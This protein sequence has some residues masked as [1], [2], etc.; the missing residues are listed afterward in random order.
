MKATLQIDIVRVDS[1]D[2]H[3]ITRSHVL[4]PHGGIEIVCI[5]RSEKENVLSVIEDHMLESISSTEWRAEE[6]ENDFSYVTEKFNHFLS[7]LAEDDVETVSG[8]FAVLRSNHLMMS[9][10]GKMRAYIHEYDDRISPIQEDTS[11]QRRFELI[12][13]GD[14]AYGSTVFLL[15]DDIIRDFWEGFFSDISNLEIPA[16]EKNARETITREKKWDL[17]MIRMAY[18]AENNL[19]VRESSWRWQTDIVKERF[20]DLQ[21]LI[22]KNTWYRNARER[23]QA[24]LYE[25]NRV[26][27]SGFLL[28]WIVL[29]FL[30]VSYIINALFSFSNNDGRD[31]KQTL[32]EAKTLIE[33]SQKIVGNQELFWEKTQAA[34]ALLEQLKAKNLYMKET[35]ELSDRIEAMKKEIYD[36]Q[37]VDLSKKKS[38]IAFNPSDISPIGAYEYEKKLFLVGKNGLISSYAP[39]DPLPKVTSYPGGEEV[40]DFSVTED[41]LML[42]LTKNRRVIAL[43]KNGDINYATVTGQDGWENWEKID[44]FNGN[45]YITD[46]RLGQIF[47]HKPWVNGYSQKNEVLSE[48]TPGIREIGIDG[49]FYL[50]TEWGKIQRIMT[51]KWYQTTGLILNKIPGTYT[52]WQENSI[53]NLILSS[54]LKY[55]YVLDGNKVWIFEPDAKRF[56]DIKAWTYIA[57]MELKTSE[58]IRNI[59]IPRDGKIYVITNLGIY[60]VWFELIDNNIIIRS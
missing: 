8:L 56:Q 49:G 44:I 10:F 9:T 27:L 22:Q 26:F 38:L 52:L 33:E 16:F 31:A 57:Q 60:D 21:S 42:W 30:L 50:L 39:G 11:E 35:A 55:V 53:L 3:A 46:S 58:E 7:H 23:I 1:P 5:F 47:K 48:T 2:R 12:S 45:I 18:R 59:S 20:K 37:T 43:R 40:I 4:R 15:S 6:E 54:N 25:K 24:F 36:I 17:H 19:G 34:N 13:S 41:G 29:F 28:V 32:L 14:I 51:A